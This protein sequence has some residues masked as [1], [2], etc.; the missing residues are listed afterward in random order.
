MDSSVKLKMNWSVGIIALLS[1]AVLSGTLAFLPNGENMN[2]HQTITENAVMEKISEVCEAVAEAAGRSYNPTDSSPDEVLRACLGL[3]T[4]EVSSAKFREALNQI[5]NQNSLVDQDSAGSNQHHFNSETFTEGHSIIRSGIAA[6]KANIRQGNLQAARETLGRVLHTLQDFYSHSNWVELGNKDTYINLIAPDL[7]IDNVADLNTPTCKDCAGG[8]CPDQILPSIKN[9]KL[10]TSGYLGLQKPAGKCSHGGNSDPTSTQVPRGGISKDERRADNANR[11][12]TAI[13][14]ATQATAELLE[15]I[16]GVA[17]NE[18]FLRLMG[19]ARSAVLSFVIDTTGSMSDDIAE[20][21]RVAFNTI[22]SKKGT[23]DE[24]SEY[25]LVP[26]ND[27]KFGPLIKT[28]NPDEMKTEISKLDA[29]GG[30]DEPEMCLSGLQLALTE[31]PSSSDIYVFTDATAKDMHLKGTI[32][33]LALSTKSRLNFFMTNNLSRR[34]RSDVA[35]TGFQVYYDLALASGGQAIQVSKSNLPKATDIILDSSTSALVTILQRARNPGPS[36]NFTFLLDASVSNITAYFTGNNLRFTLRSPKGVSQSETDLNGPLATIQ[37]VGNLRRVLLN[38]SAETGLWSVT[39]ESTQPYTVKITGQS[40]ITFLYSFVEEF[41]GP[42]PGFASF[43]SLPR[44]GV[45]AKLFLTVTGQ[46]GLEALKIQEVSLVKVSDAETVP[47][48]IT[49]LGRGNFL[50]TVNNVP[51]GEFVIMLKGEDMNTVSLFQRQSTTQM[52]LSKV[53][54]KTTVNGTMLPGKEFKVPFTVTTSGTDGLFTI[55]AKN[56]RRIP[57]SFNKGLSVTNGVGNSTVSLTPPPA[58]ASGTDVTLTILTEGSGTVESNYIV[59]R[60][61][62][63]AEVTDFTPP[64]CEIVNVST[65]CPSNSNQS[66]WDLSVNITDGNGSGIQRV[67]IQ[68]GSGNFSTVTVGNGTELVMLGFYSA[69]CS[70]QDVVISAVDKEGNVG[71]CSYN[72]TVSKRNGGP[73]LALSMPLWAF[74][75]VTIQNILQ[76]AV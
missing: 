41:T 13:K 46:K 30:G 47:G 42:H 24:P 26:F 21:K 48:T 43:D 50:V 12:D 61:T 73:T 10:L 11:H 4:G 39:V 32:S 19:I 23:Q 44:T 35:S 29:S 74:L 57:M 15:D 38:P 25:I 58:T 16:R 63:L 64:K 34:R 14:L 40:A 51:D 66:T 1:V 49:V 20:A 75:L 31:T 76:G 5:Y 2:T 33:A 9:Q 67:S 36:E 60:L 17:G 53:S 37:F 70:S 69:S 28:T 55:N 7:T 3:T 27:P 8:T 6:V 62:V 18:E 56:D 65:V 72:F 54:I 45:P 22:D 59:L 68:K 52:S 71:K